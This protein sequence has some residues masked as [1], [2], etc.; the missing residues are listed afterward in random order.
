ML[1]AG[2]IPH[3]LSPD[4]AAAGAQ[5]VAPQRVCHHVVLEIALG[6]WRVWTLHRSLFFFSRDPLINCLVQSSLWLSALARSRYLLLFDLTTQACVRVLAFPTAVKSVKAI[7]FLP[8]SEVNAQQFGRFDENGTLLISL[9]F[10]LP[11][12]FPPHF[13]SRPSCATMVTCDL[14]SLTTVASCWT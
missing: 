5:K 9:F 1:G 6:W 7:E 14:C 4:A 11:P 13:R 2:L 8:N 10:R 3:G 12:R